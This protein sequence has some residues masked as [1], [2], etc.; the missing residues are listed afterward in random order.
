[1]HWYTYRTTLLKHVVQSST[2]KLSIVYIAHLQCR[3]FSLQTLCFVANIYNRRLFV[4]P[5]S[6]K[7]LKWTLTLLNWTCILTFKH[8]DSKY[9]FVYTQTTVPW[10]YWTWCLACDDIV[11]YLPITL[12][13]M[14]AEARN[15]EKHP[16]EHSTQPIMCSVAFC[17][18]W[19]MAYS[20]FW[21]HTIGPDVL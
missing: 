18:Q 3:T 9:C 15:K 7:S 19:L 4:L 17:S 13:S 12:S 6:N 1:M 5:H 14:S 20:N 11:A 10:S 8:I 2:I 16:G 21:Y